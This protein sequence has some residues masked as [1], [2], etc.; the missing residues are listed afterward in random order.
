MTVSAFLMKPGPSGVQTHRRAQNMKILIVDDN[1]DNRRLLRYVVEKKGHE[2]IEAGDG[3]DGLRMAKIHAP[4]LIISDAL[5]PV[6]DGFQFLRAIKE[7]ERLTHIPFIFFSAIYKGNKDV[8]LAIALGAEAYIIKPKK[9]SD[10]WEEVE[11]ILE[12]Q[13]RE[14]VITPELITDEEEYLKRY[15]QVVAAK[16]EEKVAELEREIAEHK[17]T[18][19][20]LA[21]LN[22]KLK[23][24]AAELGQLFIGTITSL[25][26]AMDAKS[27]WT[28]GHSERV[29]NYAVEIGREMGLKNDA[30]ERLRLSGLLHDI[31]KIGT[32]DVLLDKLENLTDEEI[33]MIKEHPRKG[34]EII[35][36]IKQLQDVI[37]GILH[38][39]ERFDGNG[40]PDGLRAENISLCARILCAA[41]SF[42]SM[43]SDRPYRPSPGIEYAI[44]EFKRYSGTQFDPDVAEAFLRVLSRQERVA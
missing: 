6:M 10:L 1:G 29:T 20:E 43:T 42:D 11:I 41:D 18:E 8:D 14:K 30:L 25:V 17:K 32:Y 22:E 15:S 4:D 27:H 28:K 3:L 33:G 37:P 2:A 34:A 38:H 21:L 44:S 36:P 24:A 7:D 9:L 19:E 12:E 31:G 35:A 40:Y 13:K 26:S 23:E 16:L 39:H 5:M